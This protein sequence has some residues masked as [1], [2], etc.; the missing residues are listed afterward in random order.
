MGAIVYVPSSSWTT[1]ILIFSLVIFSS[2]GRYAILEDYGPVWPVRRD[3]PGFVVSNGPQLL[4]YVAIG[5]FNS[6]LLVFIY[7]VGYLSYAG[8]PQHL[9]W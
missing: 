5:I 7:L 6:M 3:W 8:A 1:R 2:D 9:L 4:S